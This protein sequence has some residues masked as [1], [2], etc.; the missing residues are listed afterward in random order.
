[1]AKNIVKVENRTIPILYLILVVP[2]VVAALDQFGIINL[3]T[4]VAPI[5]TILAGL[6]VMSE[7]GVMGMIRQRKLGKDALRI[8]GALVATIA[9]ITAALSLF[10]ITIGFLEPIQGIVNVLVILYVVIEGFR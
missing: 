6:F 8:F 4:Y 3:M 2:L 1:M 9:V 7:V 5:L 10:G